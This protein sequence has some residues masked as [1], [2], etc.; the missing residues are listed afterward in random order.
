MS[1][2]CCYC[3]NESEV[4]IIETCG[5]Y[6]GTAGPG[7]N[8]VCC[9]CGQAVVGKISSRITQLDVSCETKTLDNVFVTLEINVQ[10]HVIPG[11]EKDSFYMLDNPVG[12]IR[13]YVYD[14]VR[15]AVP[16]IPLDKVF[17]QKEEIALSVKNELSD[18]MDDYGFNILQV[19][20][21]DIEPDAKVKTA[22]NEINAAQRNR[23][24]TVD[25]AEAEKIVVIKKAE[26]EAEAMHLG[27]VG[28]A[29]QRRA[30]CEGLRD[31]VLAMNEVPDTE[32]A[33][34]MEQ[35]LL[36][37]YFDTLEDIGHRSHANVI[38]TPSAAGAADATRTGVLEAQTAMYHQARSKQQ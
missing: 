4:G 2:C 33:E 35:I 18:C 26:A 25:K 28:L 1:C 37:Q 31:S 11:K 21:A 7:C 32:P 15:S 17:E 20:I 12:Q 14:V 8:V 5:K 24:A 34:I 36:T 23:V 6:S 10:Y 27:G 30:I 16:K 13:A 3:V 19:L 22:M 9:L 38:Y 29:R